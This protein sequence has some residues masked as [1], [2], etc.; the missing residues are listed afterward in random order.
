MSKSLDPDQARHFVRLELGPDNNI[1]QRESNTCVRC[2]MLQEIFD[3]K[4]FSMTLSQGQNG[5]PNGKVKSTNAKV[6]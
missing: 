3:L 5:I 2:G 6:R 4:N 1:G